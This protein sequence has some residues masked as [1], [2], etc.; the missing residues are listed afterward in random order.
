MSLLKCCFGCLYHQIYF[1][2]CHCSYIY[3]LCFSLDYSYFFFLTFFGNNSAVPLIIDCIEKGAES[4]MNA[5]L[6]MES[7]H[8]GK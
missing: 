2:T 4:G 8:F 7:T 3:S 1:Y 5:G 6:K